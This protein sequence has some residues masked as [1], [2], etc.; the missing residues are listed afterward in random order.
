MVLFWCM[1]VCCGFGQSFEGI[2]VYHV[3]IEAAERMKFWGMTREFLIDDR[4]KDGTWA[5]TVE[6]TYKGGNYAALAHDDYHSLMIY[7]ADSNRIFAFEHGWDICTVA[8]AS[9]DF[10]FA[11]PGETPVITHSTEA[12]AAGQPCGVVRVQWKTGSCDYYYH[13]FATPIDPELY[14][15]HAHNAW[16]EFLSISHSLPFQIVKTVNHVSMTTYTLVAIRWQP[17][18]DN[19][20]A[21]PELE[22]QPDL[23]AFPAKAVMKI[24]R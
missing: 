1:A 17:V 15:C 19:V 7:R 9:Q 2:A 4:R 13:P 24:K 6:I 22:L 18:D 3:D 14:L 20:F 16:Y 10:E 5:D 12:T 21:L 23:I 8:D 11:L